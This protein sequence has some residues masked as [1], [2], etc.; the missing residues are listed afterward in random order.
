MYVPWRMLLNTYIHTYIG[1]YAAVEGATY[2]HTLVG[3]F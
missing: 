3:L 1:M 2:L